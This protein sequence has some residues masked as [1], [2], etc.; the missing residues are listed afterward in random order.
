MMISEDNIKKRISVLDAD[1]QKVS[2]Q[3]Q[4]L[5][6]QKQDAV[7]LMN[8]LNGAKQQCMSFLQDLN[9]D[10][11][12]VSDSGDVGNNADIY[13]PD[14]VKSFEGGAPT[15]ITMTLSFQETELLTKERIAL[16]Y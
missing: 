3:L 12:E 14:G 7:A 13:T 16:G 1:I 10:E 15:K 4:E 5:D 2:M 6:K 11:P 9:N 8:A